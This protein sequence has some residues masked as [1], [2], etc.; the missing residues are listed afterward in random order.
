MK[1]IIFFFLLI[2]SIISAQD[3]P[4][5][6]FT[7]TGTV[8]GLAENSVVTLIDV[9]NQSDTLARTLVKKGTFVLK[10]QIAE[11]N[12]HQLNFHE[13]KKKFTGFFGNDNM[14]ITGD[15]SMVQ[16]LNVKG[17]PT[18]DDF[19]EFQ[20]LFNPLMMR[21]SD[22]TQQ[23]NARPDI[24][25]D[26]SLMINYRLAFDRVKTTIDDFVTAKKNSPLA[27]FVIL[28]TSELEQDIAVTERRYNMISETQRSGFYG[29]ILKEQIAD[30]RVGAVGTEAI[31]FVQN[32]TTG[33]PVSLASFRGKYVLIDFWASWCGPCRMENPNVVAAYNKFKSKNFTVL[34][35]SLDRAR[36]P[37]LKAIYDDNLTWTHVS[38]LKFWNNEVAQMY[39][40]V[41]IPQ[42]FLV[43]P[44]GKIVGRNLRGTDLQ[45]KL[46]ELLGC[47]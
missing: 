30:S 19:R 26:D 17:S 43:G 32:D 27:P 29:K 13:A 7:I 41:S 16:D 46:C 33:K 6:G 2:P 20:N 21:L 8:K 37:W 3:K 4:T 12:L 31:G 22:L 5:A 18:Q 47:E 28:V 10:G 24:K 45:V 14:V 35:V 40:I 25:S 44:D 42:N 34:G 36:D 15:I 23:I 1:Q 11:P 9:N 38:D 39:K